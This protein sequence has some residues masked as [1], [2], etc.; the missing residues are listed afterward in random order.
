M[1][2]HHIL[3]WDDAYA[4]TPNI[5]G[6][7]RYPDLWVE[8]AQ[9]FRTGMLAEGRARID[10][11]YGPHARHKLDLFQPYSPAIGLVVFVHGGY[12]MKMD[13]SY[14]SMLAAGPLACGW[15]VAVPSYNLCPDVS[16]TEITREVG[17]AITGA[18]EMVTG[19]LCLTGHSAGGHLVTRMV[20]STSPL[21]AAVRARIRHT[22]S[23]SGV[24]DLRPLLH[25]AMNTTLK[26]DEAE[27]QRESPALLVPLPGTRLTCWVGAAERSEFIRQSALLAN[28]WTGLGA[29]T[30]CVLEP[31]RHHFNV[32]DG[33][34]EARSTLTTALVGE[35]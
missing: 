11:A 3:D 4:N 29:H 9:S 19:P 12:W 31:D 33:L 16:I 8:A 25:T 22:L 32:I 21:T 10:V 2:H 13:K 1:I 20:T 14:F 7:E 30:A 6:G 28:A 5:P 23:I 26:L 24:H 15:A 35:A 34:R 17:A 18:A 27:A